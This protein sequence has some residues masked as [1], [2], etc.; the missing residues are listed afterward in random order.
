MFLKKVWNQ[1]N[2]VGTV[3]ISLLLGAGF[4]YAFAFDGFDVESVS[5]DE[6]ETWLEL[7]VGPNYGK[8]CDSDTC[9]KLGAGCTGR[10]DDPCRNCTF[11]DSN[12]SSNCKHGH[13]GCRKTGKCPYN[14]LK[15]NKYCSSGGNTCP[16]GSYDTSKC[17]KK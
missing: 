8:N 12:C 17:N 16:D 1:P 6:V 14:N 5:G 13:Q 2:I 4:V 3:M 15:N 10:D 9:L 7:S 11:Q